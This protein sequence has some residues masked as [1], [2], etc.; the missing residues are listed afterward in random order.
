MKNQSFQKDKVINTQEIG[1]KKRIKQKSL[2]TIVAKKLK[3]ANIVNQNVRQ[4]SQTLFQNKTG[5]TESKNIKISDVTKE[6]LKP[7]KV[8]STVNSDTNKPIISFAKTTKENF[9]KTLLAKRR[10]TSGSEQKKSLSDIFS[11]QSKNQNES[12]ISI[13]QKHDKK[14]S[15][16]VDTK[17]SQKHDINSKRQKEFMTAATK[18]P[19]SKKAKGID[20]LNKRKYK[21]KSI[22]ND[23][24]SDKTPKLIHRVGKTSSLFGNNPDVPTIGQRFVKPVHE[25]VF[26]EITFADLNIHPFMVGIYI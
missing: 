19:V 16:T 5:K 2:S 14:E 18:S 23:R 7:D 24:E 6:D 3:Q 15:M 10:S 20:I 4:Q 21:E 17:S 22:D 26:T 12:N 11:S 25:P 1:H 13:I 9:G 8:F